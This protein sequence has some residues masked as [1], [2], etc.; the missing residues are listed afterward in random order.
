MRDEIDARLWNDSH[1]PLS[2]LIDAGV[3]KL[4]SAFARLPSWDGSTQ[5]LLA[6]VASFAIT[7]LSLNTTTTAV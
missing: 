2:D 1:E 6:L 3:A 4:R 7:A 5:H